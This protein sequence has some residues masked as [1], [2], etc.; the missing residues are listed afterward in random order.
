VIEHNLHGGGSDGT[1]IV[2]VFVTEGG[3][4]VKIMPTSITKTSQGTV[5]IAFSAPRSGEAIIIV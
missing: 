1:P 4:T 3:N 2:D 5:T